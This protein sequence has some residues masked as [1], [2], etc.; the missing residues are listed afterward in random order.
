MF[1]PIAEQCARDQNE[2]LR[3]AFEQCETELRHALR[4][5]AQEAL[6]PCCG[7]ETPVE[8]DPHP[9]ET[10]DPR[11]R[12]VVRVLQ[13][14]QH[15]LSL[16]I[17][18]PKGENY[19]LIDRFIRRKKDVVKDGVQYRGS[20]VGAEWTTADAKTWVIDTPYYKNGMYSWCG[21][22]VGTC[23]GAAGMLK[24]HRYNTMPSCTRMNDDWAGTDIEIDRSDIEPGDIVTV[25][26]ASDGTNHKGT[27]IVLC[28]ERYPDHIVTIEGNAKWQGRE[29]VIRRT[30]PFAGSGSTYTIK[31]AYRPT[32][33]MF[34]SLRPEQDWKW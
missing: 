4:E 34:G 16:G 9:P 30:R 11:E 23:M 7:G 33:E 28:V 15:Y 29:G 24:E 6:C 1:E 13:A 10:A 12:R 8:P 5:A 19:D 26:K 27:H 31:R 2:V 22:F 17:T 21:A 3:Q 18:E 25:G 32:D 14:A 20:S